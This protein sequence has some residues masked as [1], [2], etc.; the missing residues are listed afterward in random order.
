MISGKAGVVGDLA[1]V[2]A[3]VCEQLRRAAGGQDLDVA[4]G[5]SPRQL[6]QAGL[7]GNRKEARGVPAA[8]WASSLK[9]AGAGAGGCTAQ[10]CLRADACRERML[11][12][13]SCAGCS[14]RG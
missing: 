1:H 8:A 13:I 11:I 3:V 6:D 4:A 12:A 10:A 2:H 7:V 5:E 9:R 14:T